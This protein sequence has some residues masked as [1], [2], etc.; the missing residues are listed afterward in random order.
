[1]VSILL[2]KLYYS[3]T[4]YLTTASV[5]MDRMP[6]SVCMNSSPGARI[7]VHEFY[8][9]VEYQNSLIPLNNCMYKKFLF[10]VTK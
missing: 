2:L 5:A 6:Q 9:Y 8:V 7:L 1:M 3:V 10:F 4:R